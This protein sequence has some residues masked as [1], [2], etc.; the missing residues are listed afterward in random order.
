M[1][2]LAQDLRTGGGR[3]DPQ[4][5]HYS[6]SELMTVIATEFIPLL[7]LSIVPIMVMWESSQWLGKN[8]VWSPGW[9]KLRKARLGALAAV[10]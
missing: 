5:G 1:P 9:K 6:F 4:L 10:I 7:P 3:F 8:I 2:L